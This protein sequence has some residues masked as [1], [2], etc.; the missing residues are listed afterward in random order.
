MAEVVLIDQ[1]LDP[2]AGDPAEPR[3]EGVR[4]EAG[5]SALGVDATEEPL[6]QFGDPATG[7]RLNADCRKCGRPVSQPAFRAGGE[8]AG[9]LRKIIA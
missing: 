1:L 6:L 8:G 9:Q 5:R 3:I 2:N 4:R 7:R